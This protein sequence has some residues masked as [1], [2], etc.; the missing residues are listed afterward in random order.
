MKEETSREQ[1]REAALRR[2]KKSLGQEYCPYY[3]ICCL[4]RDQCRTGN[5]ASERKKT[6]KREEEP[7]WT[8]E[9]RKKKK[10]LR[11]HETGNLG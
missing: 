6:K 2:K 9:G 5:R 8:E 3:G 11:G 10:D 7:S 1:N 4:K